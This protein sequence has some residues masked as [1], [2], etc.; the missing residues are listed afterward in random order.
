MLEIAQPITGQEM[1]EIQWSVTKSFPGLG[2]PKIINS[3]TKFELKV[4]QWFVYKCMETT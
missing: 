4:D 1:A 3:S 2:S